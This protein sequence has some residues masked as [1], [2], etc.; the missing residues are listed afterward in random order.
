[1]RKEVLIAI[2]LGA[3]L[4]IV[5]AFGVWRANIALAPKK[6]VQVEVQ[7]SPTSLPTFTLTITSPQADSVVQ[8][9]TISV[10]GTTKSK[11][12]VTI[13]YDKGEQIVIAEEDGSFTSEVELVAGANT[14]NISSFDEEGESSEKV[15]TV[16]FSTEFPEKE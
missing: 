16:V 10:T 2:I 9:S 3:A 8:E 7:P 15:L 13:Q 4:G 5:I 1:M 14:I 12:S 6:E 11:A